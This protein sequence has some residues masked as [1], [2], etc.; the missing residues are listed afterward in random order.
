MM[1]WSAI[2]DPHINIDAAMLSIIPSDYPSDVVERM[3]ELHG[4]L[5]KEMLE[6]VP[7]S[8]PDLLLIHFLD[9]AADNAVVASGIG[10]AR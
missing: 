4:K 2:C 8:M 7:V 5:R 6:D 10:S 1:V 9:G 3:R